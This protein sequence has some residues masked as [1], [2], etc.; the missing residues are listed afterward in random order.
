MA[1][2]LALDSQIGNDGRMYI[3]LIGILLPHPKVRL[4][5][6]ALDTVQGHHVKLPDGFVILRRIAGSRDDPALRYLVASKC[7]ALEELKHGRRQCLGNAVDL[8]DEQYAFLKSAVLN[9]I[10]NGRHDLA[11]GILCH[12]VFP[13][14][15][16]FPVYKGKSHRA[17]SCV[18]GDGICHQPNPALP[19]YLF[20]DLGLTHAGRPN[21]KNRPLTDGGNHILPIIIL[22]KICLYGV[23]NLFLCPLNIH[24]SCSPASFGFP[25]YSM[26]CSSLSTTFMAQAGTDS[27]EN[28]FSIKTNAVS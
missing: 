27:S 6:N 13:A 2:V 4:H 28:I 5:I 7:L 25:L 19:G 8:I 12:R 18:V 9:F 14:S 10:I 11:H 16:H 3:L 26:I 22:Q 1:E 23:L 17:L 20:H 15:K 21:Q 24:E